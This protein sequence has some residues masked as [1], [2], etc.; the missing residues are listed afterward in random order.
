MIHPPRRLLLVKPSSMG[1]IV[2]T[3]PVLAALHSGW[4]GTKIDWVVKPEWMTLLE[5]HPMLHDVVSFPKNWRQWGR[6]IGELRRRRYDMVIDLQGLLRSGLLSVMTGAPVRVGFAN[7]REGS[8]WCYTH[9]I[10]VP[11]RVIHSVE[12][13]LHLVWHVGV[14][15]DIPRTFPLPKWRETEAW[16]GGLWQQE[17]IAPEEAVC[18]IHPAARGANRR[19][20]AERYAE[21]ADRLAAKKGCRVVLV[22]AQT[23]LDQ[24]NAVRRLMRRRAINLAGQT[25]LPQLVALLRK[26]TLLITNV[27][28]P[29]HLSAAVGTPVVGILGPTDPEKMGPYGSGHIVLKKDVDCSSCGRQRCVNGLACL[30]SISVD[31]VYRAVEAVV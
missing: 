29:M 18:L 30:K 10:T 23:Q 17:G 21:L 14:P 6:T 11:Y 25:T 3:L 9:R 13:Y 20:P 27:S 24:L 26:A 16:V 28:G 31:E 19:W 7:A 1:D 8:P 5:N 15:K 2:H 12:R 22:G 4:P